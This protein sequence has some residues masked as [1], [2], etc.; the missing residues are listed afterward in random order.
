MSLVTNGV[1]LQRPTCNT[2]S[3]KLILYVLSGLAAT[4][5]AI[6]DV[7]VF[8]WYADMRSKHC[9]SMRLVRSKSAA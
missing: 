9:N 8:W 1:Q 3:R 5:S 6:D 2:G 7:D 4:T